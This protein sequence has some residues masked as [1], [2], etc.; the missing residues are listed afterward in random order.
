MKK[1]KENFA[2]EI[3]GKAIRQRNIWI[4]IAIISIVINIIQWLF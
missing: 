1:E 2:I 3:I 4:M